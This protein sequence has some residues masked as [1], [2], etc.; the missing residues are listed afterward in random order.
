MKLVYRKHHW[1]EGKSL[2]KS[3]TAIR[4]LKLSRQAVLK[5]RPCS[6]SVVLRIEELEWNLFA[7]L[8]FNPGLTPSDYHRFGPFKKHLGGKHFKVDND[9]QQKVGTQVV[10]MATL[11]CSRHWCI[12]KSMGEGDKCNKYSLFWLTSLLWLI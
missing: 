4:K 8:V 7:H 2:N 10:Q 3:Q 6:K 11:L 12:D 1:Y 9:A 5:W